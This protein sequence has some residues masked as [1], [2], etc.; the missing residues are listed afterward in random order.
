MRRILLT[1]EYKG[2]NYAGWQR[3]ENALAVQQVLEDAL[4]KMLQQKVVLIASGRTDAGVHALGQK[5]HFDYDGNF[6]LDRIPIASQTILPPDI[7]ILRAEEVSS[8]LHA[9]YSAKKKTY[10]YQMYLSRENHPLLN[11]TYAP[12]PYAESYFDFSKVEK[13]AKDLIGTHDFAGFANKGSQVR[14]TVRTIYD[15]SVKKEGML[16]TFDITGNGFLYNMVRIIAGTLVYIGLGKRTTDSIKKILETQNRN[17]AGK[18]FPP[19]G[20]CLMN[21]EYD[22]TN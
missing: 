17:L 7:S 2:T 22:E 10:R 15:V 21:V 18:T 11:D 9:Q 13:A 8:D 4:E 3:Q 20:L 1:I 5:A 12:V 14:S 6:P 16:L 19:Q